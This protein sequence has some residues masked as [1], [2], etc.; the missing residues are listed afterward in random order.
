MTGDTYIDILHENLEISLIQ[1]GLEDNFMLQDNDPKHTVKK[2]KMFLTFNH[3]K[4]LDWAP[5][6]P[7]LNRFWIKIWT[8]SEL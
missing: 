3:I 5:Q 4:M 1:L 6:F 7:D 2:T 8:K